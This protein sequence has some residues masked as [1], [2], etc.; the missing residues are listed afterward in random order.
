MSLKRWTNGG[1]APPVTKKHPEMWERRFK[2]ALL[3][4][5]DAIFD[6]THRPDTSN[7]GRLFRRYDEHHKPVVP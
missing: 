3:G 6:G 5:I 7:G 4:Q 1:L 2:Q